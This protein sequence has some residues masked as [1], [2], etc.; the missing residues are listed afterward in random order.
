MSLTRSGLGSVIS[1]SRDFAPRSLGTIDGM[2]I[3]AL[4][5]PGASIWLPVITVVRAPKAWIWI[6]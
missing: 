3:M 5:A 6:V 4:H 2:T 1:L